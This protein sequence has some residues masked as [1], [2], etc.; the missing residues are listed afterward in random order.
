MKHVINIMSFSYL[1]FSYLTLYPSTLLHHYISFPILST[2]SDNTESNQHQVA[3]GW[4]TTRMSC[5][6]YL[7]VSWQD[8]T[9]DRIREAV[10]QI[11]LNRGWQDLFHKDSKEHHA[12]HKCFL[13][14]NRNYTSKAALFVFRDCLRKL[15]IWKNK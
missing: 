4:N 12:L 3:K 5:E 6:S 11:N 15:L 1:M 10:C 9:T 14:P 13:N 7:K 8:F 2:I